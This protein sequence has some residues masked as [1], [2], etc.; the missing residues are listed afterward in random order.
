MLLLISLI[1]LDARARCWLM[2]IPP[3]LRTLESFFFWGGGVLPQHLS[4]QPLWQQAIQMQKF[5]FELSVT[6]SVR[7]LM[8]HSSCLYLHARN[9][10]PSPFAVIHSHDVYLMSSSSSL[11]FNSTGPC[12]KPVLG[13]VQT[14]PSS[15][16]S[17]ACNPLSGKIWAV[18]YSS[19]S[20]RIQSVLCSTTIYKI[21][22]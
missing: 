20:L 2:F 3:S 12:T 8:I 22:I 15:L 6:L 11:V 18:D 9:T 1:H 16:R 21:P 5:K 10:L 13:A 17:S 19:L 14:G 4:S 7:F